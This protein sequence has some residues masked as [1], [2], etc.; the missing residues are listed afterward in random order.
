ML[1]FGIGAG[2]AILGKLLCA[3]V[4]VRMRFIIII[5]VVIGYAVYWVVD[6]C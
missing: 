4:G 2:R 3:G 1:Y 6:K 5:V